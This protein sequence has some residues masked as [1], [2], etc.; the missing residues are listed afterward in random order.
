[1]SV[2]LVS[3]VRGGGGGVGAGARARSK[4]VALLVK[5]MSGFGM[6]LHTM[7]NV[8]VMG[9]NLLVDRRCADGWRGW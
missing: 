9:Y 8:S 3:R 5:C 6:F 4:P 7:V 1:M 2:S